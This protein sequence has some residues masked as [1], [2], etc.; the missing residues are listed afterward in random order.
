MSFV[1][2]IDSDERDFTITSRVTTRAGEEKIL[3]LVLHVRH[4]YSGSG[5]RVQLLPVSVLTW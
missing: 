2:E 1:N 5:S 3:R 4:T